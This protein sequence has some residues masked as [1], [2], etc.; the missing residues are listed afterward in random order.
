MLQRLHR[1]EMALA[2]YA[3]HFAALQGAHVKLRNQFHGMKGG[4]P[5]ASSVSEIPHGDKAA[6]R[7]AL[8]VVPGA[9]FV[10]KE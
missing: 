4:R 7:R 5:T 8:G 10:H 6:L 2:Q 1:L 3:E 9:R